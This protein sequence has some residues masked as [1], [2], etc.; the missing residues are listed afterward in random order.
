MF[1]G[2]FGPELKYAGYDKIVIRGK[3]PNL[4]KSTT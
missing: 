1:G 4:P 3:S 2:Y